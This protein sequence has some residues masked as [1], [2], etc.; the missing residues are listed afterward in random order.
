MKSVTL[1]VLLFGLAGLCLSAEDTGSQPNNGPE[2]GNEGG[3]RPE[4]PDG[5]NEGGDR[6]TRNPGWRNA[7]HKLLDASKSTPKY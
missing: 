6:Q 7:V 5:G 4:I 1:V 2:T 3:G